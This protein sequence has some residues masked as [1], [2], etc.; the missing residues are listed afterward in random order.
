MFHL[1]FF[2]SSLLSP[3]V[4]SLQGVATPPP[5]QT[6]PTPTDR[7]LEMTAQMQQQMQRF[8]TTFEDKETEGNWQQFD[9]ALQQ[10]LLW[11]KDEKLVGSVAAGTASFLAT[12]AKQLKAGIVKCVGFFVSVV[13]SLWL[14]VALPVCVG[15]CV[16]LCLCMCMCMCVDHMTPETMPITAG[17]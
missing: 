4:S 15:V 13:R 8:L 3:L 16:C 5:Y 7:R 14:T 10:I 11:S 2:V 6:P 1:F 17:L 9:A 12:V